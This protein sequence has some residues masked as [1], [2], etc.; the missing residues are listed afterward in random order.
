MKRKLMTACAVATLMLAITPTS[1]AFQTPRHPY[2]QAAI[3]S[4]VVAKGNLS[5]A[6][7]DFG[8]H[9]MA[10]VAA[11]DE[12]IRQLRICNEY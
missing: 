2:I 1:P 10:A 4:L 7:H 9:R 6:N 3:D 8:G 11:I 12:A 5:A